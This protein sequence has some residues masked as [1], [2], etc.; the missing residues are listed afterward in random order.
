M[1]DDVAAPSTAPCADRVIIVAGTSRI[2]G[3]NYGIPKK[4]FAE[5]LTPARRMVAL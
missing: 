2:T 5:S 4:Y 1:H 3:P